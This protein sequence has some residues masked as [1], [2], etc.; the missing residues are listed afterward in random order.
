MCKQLTVKS[1]PSLH[2][3]KTA[4]VRLVTI[5]ETP[6]AA[7]RQK[8]TVPQRRATQENQQCEPDAEKAGR[9][10]MEHVSKQEPATS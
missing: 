5:F 9:T 6:Q 4:M 8:I 1:S 7:L 3:A 10:E 2:T